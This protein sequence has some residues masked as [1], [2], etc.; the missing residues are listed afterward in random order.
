[1]ALPPFQSFACET[2]VQVLD[3]WVEE[4]NFFK[5][6]FAVTPKGCEGSCRGVIEFEV[7]YR[8]FAS[9]QVGSVYGMALWEFDPEEE[10]STETVGTAHI[11]LPFCSPR[12][13]CRILEV[14][15]NRVQCSDD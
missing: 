9:N 8:A 11:T 6:Q 3:F 10:S 13:P 4:G 1:M 2:E 5:V 15:T 7:T 14:E 12:A